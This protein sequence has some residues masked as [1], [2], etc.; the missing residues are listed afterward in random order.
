FGSSGCGPLYMGYERRL[1]A[2]RG[3]LAQPV[4][5]CARY[6]KH[7]RTEWLEEFSGVKKVKSRP[8]A[9]CQRHN[10]FM[11]ASARLQDL[12]TLFDSRIANLGW[13][14]LCQT[15]L[16]IAAERSQLTVDAF[17]STES[18]VKHRHAIDSPAGDAQVARLQSIR[19]N[20]K[21]SRDTSVP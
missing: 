17:R 6:L 12:V 14:R 20:G 1:R 9:P 2:R 4:T 16:G 10:R 8:D 7:G 3:H 5:F 11:L 19:L 15:N 13:F 21:G 18:C